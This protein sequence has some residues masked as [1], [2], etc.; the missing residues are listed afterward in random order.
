MPAIDSPS[1]S[2]RTTGGRPSLPTARSVVT[3]VLARLQRTV[4]I[5]PDDLFGPSGGRADDDLDALL[6]E[7]VLSTSPHATGNNQIHPLLVQPTGQHARLVNRWGELTGVEHLPLRS[8]D[9]EQGTAPNSF[10]VLG[11]HSESAAPIL[12]RSSV[13]NGP[14]RRPRNPWPQERPNSPEYRS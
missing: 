2:Y 9:I 13:P 6:G 1:V 7:D 12:Q 14:T 10:R 11:T 5:T 4:E 3:N 8:I